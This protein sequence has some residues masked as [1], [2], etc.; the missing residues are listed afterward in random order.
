MDGL[1]IKQKMRRKITSKIIKGKIL[2][3]INNAGWSPLSIRE[4]TL[5]LKEEYDIKLSPQVVKRHLFKLKK[6]GKID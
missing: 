2:K 4:V 1:Y 3:I 5:K 6:E